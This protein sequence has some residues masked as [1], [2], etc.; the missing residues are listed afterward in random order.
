MRHMTRFLT[1]EEKAFEMAEFERY[2]ALPGI[3]RRDHA[4]DH[5]GRGRVD[6]EVLPLCDALNALDGV[7]TIQS[8]CGHVWQVPGEP[9]GVECVHRG[10]LWIRLDERMA[11]NFDFHIG[12]LLAHDVIWHA[13]KLY[14]FQGEAATH[15]VFDVMWVEGRM[16]EAEAV[17]REFFYAIYENDASSLPFR[18]FG[19]SESVSPSTNPPQT[20]EGTE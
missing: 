20:S 4:D 10:Q 1:P 7:C 6:H 5:G 8:C 19:A 13:Q 2:K 14:S 16:D 3:W 18:E 12:V 9:E 11:R 17:I 15:E